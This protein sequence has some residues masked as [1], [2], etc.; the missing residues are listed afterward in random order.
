MLGRYHRHASIS[1]CPCLPSTLASIRGTGTRLT[2]SR[3]FIRRAALR[4]ASASPAISSRSI[5]T[6]SSVSPFRA[7][8]AH[9]SKLTS[10]TFRRF[11]SDEIKAAVEAAE[12]IEGQAESGIES[13]EATEH[14]P[15]EEAL[16]S[17]AYG[18]A[19]STPAAARNAYAGS[20]SDFAPRDGA[21]QF[22]RPALAPNNSVYVGNLQF[23][24]VESDLQRE[25]APFGEIKKALV[26]TD[27]RGLSKGYV[28]WSV[29]FIQ[30]Y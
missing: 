12:A 20:R 26:A 16:E 28:E 17:A 22:T 14:A 19:A 9:Q 15:G 24:V 13:A 3:H 30:R 10:I 5:S 29:L 25:F 2:F 4:A 18:A 8:L 11:N 21:K 1:S 23:D 6:R 27:L 7:Q